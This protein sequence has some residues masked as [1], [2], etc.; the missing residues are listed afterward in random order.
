MMA[1]DTSGA[2]VV[3]T[4]ALGRHDRS[5]TFKEVAH[6]ADRHWTHHLELEGPDDIDDEVAA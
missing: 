3:P 6:P 1:G 5:S 2:E 4:I